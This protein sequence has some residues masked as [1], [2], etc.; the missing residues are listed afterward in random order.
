M[1]DRRLF[2]IALVFLAGCADRPGP[3]VLVTEDH[4]LPHEKTVKIF[5][6]TNRQ[7]APVAANAFTDHPA[8]TVSYADY[9][10]AIPPDHK[11]GNIEWPQGKPNPAHDFTVLKQEALQRQS[12]A[13]GIAAEAARQ[14]R[15]QRQ[16]GI[17]VHGFNYNFAEALFRA[18]QMSADTA[19]PGVPVI[20]SWPSQARLTGYLA[21]KEAV[22]YSRDDLVR[23]L[24]DIAQ[25]KTVDQ[26]V[27]FGHSLGSWLVME[28]VRQLKLEGRED[29]IAK[30][31]VVLAAPDIDTRV[32]RSQLDV[33]GPMSKPITLL[34][35][36]DDLA[37][38]LSS[39]VASDSRRIGALNVKDPAVQEAARKYHVE[40]IDISTLK[41]SD[42][43]NHD[44]YIGIARILP[45][46]ASKGDSV[47]HAGAFI[48][49]AASKTLSTPFDLAS[50][51]V[52]P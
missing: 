6:A 5:A 39:W 9:R 48:L 21:D 4:P 3:S 13:D 10:I 1:V 7:P 32:F 11:V 50:R 2:A 26:I 27:L 37:L 49:D 47:R 30:L 41:G 12:F 14:P 43:V 24:K 36:P 17:F 52:D 34:V 51:A 15:G 40:V 44:K 25:E 22:T 38:K 19:T 35:S 29:V 16:V 31:N 23:C 20:Y 33:I 8:Q 28:A 18:T 42:G 46:L 45:S